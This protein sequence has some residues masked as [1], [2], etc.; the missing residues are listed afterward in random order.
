MSPNWPG[1]FGITSTSGNSTTGGL[2]VKSI[3]ETCYYCGLEYERMPGEISTHLVRYYITDDEGVE[4]CQAELA[5]FITRNL[6]S[7]YVDKDGK[8]K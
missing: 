4:T 2:V 3:K 1:I 7:R 6:L 5:K 8:P